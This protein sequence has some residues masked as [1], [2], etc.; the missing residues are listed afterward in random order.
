[1][2]MGVEFTAPLQLFLAQAR[3][4]TQVP[5]YSSVI[6]QGELTL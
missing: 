3:N 2:E 5:A 4:H 6:V 1:M